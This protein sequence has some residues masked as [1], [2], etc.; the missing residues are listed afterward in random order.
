M[1]KPIALT[2]CTSSRLAAHGYDPETKTLAIQFKGKGD[3]P[4]PC[5]HYTNFEPETYAELKE[6]ESVGGFF[7]SRINIKVDGEWKYPFTRL[8][9]DKE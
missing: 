9:E 4:G 7:G 5:Y 6:A 8:T 1:T 3:S 2:P